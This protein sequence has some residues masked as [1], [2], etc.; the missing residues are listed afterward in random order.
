MPTLFDKNLL[1]EFDSI[2]DDDEEILWT[3]KP[4]FVPYAITGLGFG[5]GAV[6]F[7][8]LYYVIT[9][10]SKNSDGTTV[11][12][13]W[14]FAAIPFMFFIWTFF[15]KIFSYSNTRYAYSNKRIMMRTGFIG[16]DFKTIDY[17]KITD[18]EVTV[19]IIE[20]AFNVGSIKFFSGRTEVNDGVTKKIFDHWESIPNPYE[21]FKQVK[22]ISVD[23]K[24]DYN[25]PNALR[26]ETNP[27]YNTKYQP[28]N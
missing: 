12:F 6:I 23:I 14:F 15:T 27:G 11:E 1:P 3:D 18:M 9:A 13:N 24:T 16:T 28:D 2:K 10:N 7:F 26:P 4:K 5:I 25:Y 19:N 22:K 8:I 20:R 17:D 21:V